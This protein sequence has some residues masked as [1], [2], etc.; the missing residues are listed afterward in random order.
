MVEK[1][2]DT[3]DKL[4]EKL[5]TKLEVAEKELDQFKAKAPIVGVRWYGKGGFGIGLSRMVGGVNKVALEGYNDKAV[6]DYSAWIRV[7]NTEEAQAGILVRDDSVIDEV[8]QIGSVA[9]KDQNKSPNTY[10]RGEIELILNGSMPELKEI[11]STF[12]HYFPALH[13]KEVAESMK[14]K[15]EGKI[16]V[17]KDK[18][19]ELY[20]KFRWEKLHH[21]ELVLAVDGL[22]QP[23]ETMTDEQMVDFLVKH[24]L[25][26]NE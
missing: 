8:G 15:N 11:L 20:C 3:R 4:I 18:F 17:I 5:Q 19:N 12:T 9:K 1:L 2:E 10:T 25:K 22:K 6:I 13:F 24:E 14:V 23:W 26:G 21:H 16:K 7:R